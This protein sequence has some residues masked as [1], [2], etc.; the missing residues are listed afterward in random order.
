MATILTTEVAAVGK[1]EEDAS[2][3]APASLDHACVERSFRLSAWVPTEA[4]GRIIGTKG[5]VIQHIQRETST[6]VVS[7]PALPGAGLWSPVSITGRPSSVRQAYLL[8]ATIAEEEDDVVAEFRCPFLALRAARYGQRG[9]FVRRLSAEHNVRVFVPEVRTSGR[10]GRGGD[11]GGDRDRDGAGRD[12]SLEGLAEGVWGAL[13]D[14]IAHF[15]SEEGQPRQNGEGEGDRPSWRGG[16]ATGAGAGAPAAASVTP[17]QVEGGFE[18][19]VHVPA[20]TVSALLSPRLPPSP[21]SFVA[22]VGKATHTSISSPKR[23]QAAGRGRGG[24]G[25][26]DGDKHSNSEVFAFSITGKNSHD[27]ALAAGFLLRVLQGERIQAVLQTVAG[28]QPQGE[29]EPAPAEPAQG[30]GGG[31]PPS[32]AAE[33]ASSKS[34]SKSKSV[35]NGGSG[36]SGSKRKPVP[37]RPETLRR[38]QKASAVP[39]SAG[40]GVDVNAQLSAAPPAAPAVAARAAGE[41]GQGRGSSRRGRGG[42]GGSGKRG[43]SRGGRGTGSKPPPASK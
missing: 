7:L 15:K 34:S 33:H 42:G 30:G 18:H 39:S 14:I 11:R 26:G 43:G 16:E 8:I 5:S 37:D 2:G 10:G 20:A 6:R 23:V 17:R 41:Q 36:G 32:K 19:S 28:C 9:P 1:E 4:I 3:A 35:A 13:G 12:M 38:S 27:V 31:K 24:G 21:G 25:G 29:P 22:A 40:A